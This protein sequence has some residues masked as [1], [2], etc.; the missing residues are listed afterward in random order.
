MIIEPQKIFTEFT[1]PGFEPEFY[2]G[3]LKQKNINE[4]NNRYRYLLS[5][6]YHLAQD[7]DEEK[8]ED[9]SELYPIME[10]LLTR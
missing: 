10:E 3:K 4:S 9:W 5:M 6:Y 1:P 2:Q 7:E 8:E